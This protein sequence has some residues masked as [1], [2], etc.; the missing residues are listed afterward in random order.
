MYHPNRLLVLESLADG[1]TF[2]TL[3]DGRVVELC[4]ATTHY[5]LAYLDGGKVEAIDLELI[6]ALEVKEFVR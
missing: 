4:G 5:A 2:A 6:T 1:P 3:T